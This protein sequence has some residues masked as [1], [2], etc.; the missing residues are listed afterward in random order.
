MAI[1]AERGKNDVLMEI[2][3]KCSVDLG[4]SSI[5]LVLLSDPGTWRQLLMV[6]RVGLSACN[7]II[8]DGKRT[9]DHSPKKSGQQH[10]IA[11]ARLCSDVPLLKR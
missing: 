6:A 10:Q 5:P 9:S 8:D 7:Q 3:K 4:P 11:Q 2:R 1:K